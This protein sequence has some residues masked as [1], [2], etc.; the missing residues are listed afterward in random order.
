MFLVRE[1]MPLVWAQKP[2]VKLLVVGKDPPAKVRSLA[3]NPA[4]TVTG[5]VPDLRPYLRKA[6]LAVVPLVYGAGFQNKVVEAMACGTPVV[7]TPRAILTL[8]AQPG[9][10]LLVAEKPDGIAASILQLVDNP[11]YRRQVG[12]NGRRYV[13][14]NHSWSG[15][16]GQLEDVYHKAI[17]AQFNPGKNKLVDIQ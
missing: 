9:R 13:Q 5:T 11:D 3:E 15:V 10:D 2:E 14:R 12:V 6:T 4:I 8:S 7:A 1:V 16:A 17:Q